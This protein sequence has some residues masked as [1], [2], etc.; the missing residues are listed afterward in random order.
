MKAKRILLWIC[1]LP[2][3]LLSGLLL[4][5]EEN[6]PYGSGGI[7]LGAQWI[8]T[9]SLNEVLAA[10]GFATF[11]SPDLS[12]G[13]ESYALIRNRLLFGPEF[14][15]FLQEVSNAT[16][17]QRLNGYWG[18]FNFGYALVSGSGKGF[19]VYP[20]VGL[21][22]SWLN[23]RLTERAILDFSDITTDPKRESYLSRWGFLMQA[24]VG[25]DYR[26]IF[27]DPQSGAEGGFFIG[28]RFG[29]QYTLAQT[30]WKMSGM[31]VSGATDAN[32]SGFFF[33]FVVGGTGGGKSPAK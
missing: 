28:V 18:F 33:R 22:V 13:F 27:V 3:L 19:H 12:I 32:V 4:H 11:N 9:D 17:M 10:N 20:I 21:G 16:Y 26:I 8:N 25:A 29:Y 1:I 24:A 5:A 7:A 30:D 15:F 23:L 2:A 14:Q 6:V 31:T